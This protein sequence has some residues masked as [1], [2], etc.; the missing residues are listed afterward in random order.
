MAAV[1]GAP[2]PYNMPVQLL[3]VLAKQT[4]D[5]SWLLAKLSPS[6]AHA[7]EADASKGDEWYEEIPEEV[8]A[9]AQAF[10]PFPKVKAALDQVTNAVKEAM[11]PHTPPVDCN[12]YIVTLCQNFVSEVLQ[13]RDRYNDP[14]AVEVDEMPAP[15]VE[16]P[17][18]KR[19]TTKTRVEE[20]QQPLEQIQQEVEDV[21]LM[22]LGATIPHIPSRSRRRGRGMSKR[23]KVVTF[24][25]GNV[26]RYTDKAESFAHASKFDVM[27]Y[28]EHHLR[29]E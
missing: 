17:K 4:Y 12:K 26:N 18:K 28:G 24:F 27:L 22:L 20:R 5:Q 10:V 15:K 29:G 21:P 23:K 2:T 14:E 1:A 9:T 25:Y 16:P 8:G 11:T 3:A 6:D 19:L 7:P 13:A